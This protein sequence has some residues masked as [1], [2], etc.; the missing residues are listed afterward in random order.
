VEISEA[1]IFFRGRSAVLVAQ[2]W[3]KSAVKYNIL[4]S[5]L[6]FDLGLV[7]WF[8][9]GCHSQIVAGLIVSVRNISEAQAGCLPLDSLRSI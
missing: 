9:G 1:L 7:R 4:T 8:R 5:V 3:T 6:T 2:A